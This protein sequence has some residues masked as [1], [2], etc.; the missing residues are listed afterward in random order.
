MQRL[1]RNKIQILNRSLR[2]LWMV[3]F[4]VVVCPAF[5]ATFTAS[6]DRTSVVMGEQV[7]LTLNFEGAKP[8]E[9]ANPAF[10]GVQVVSGVSSQTSIV[11]TPSGQSINY[12]YTLQLTPT[13]TGDVVIPAIAAKVNG[14][15]V[16]SQ[17]ITLKVTAVDPATS[18][19]AEY[20]DKQVFL[21]IVLS[22]TNLFLNEPMV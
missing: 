12:V 7:V 19:P 11:S 2:G 1:T 13:R 4:F 16:R 6:L 5:A 14:A 8:D 18:P 15:T 3:L 21:W 20:A 22:K 10:D 17:P 9:I